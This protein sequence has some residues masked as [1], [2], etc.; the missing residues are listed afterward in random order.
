MVEEVKDIL[1]NL[2]EPLPDDRFNETAV[3]LQKEF[4]IH[5]SPLFSYQILLT[6]A[7]K[8][9]MNCAVKTASPGNYTSIL[10][11]K[12]LNVHVFRYAKGQIER[13]KNASEWFDYNYADFRWGI[14]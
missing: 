12:G 2:S 10:D 11:F 4:E 8:A 3:K 14:E 1:S 7:L 5:G 9:P 13:A 6:K